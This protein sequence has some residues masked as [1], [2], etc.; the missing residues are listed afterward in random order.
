MNPHPYLRQADFHDPTFL[1]IRRRVAL[2]RLPYAD[3]PLRKLLLDSVALYDD[4]LK[5]RTNLGLA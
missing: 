2:L 1:R 4:L 3:G 5:E